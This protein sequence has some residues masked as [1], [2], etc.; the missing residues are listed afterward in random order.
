MPADGARLASGCPGGHVFTTRRTW[1]QIA[2]I[3]EL[4]QD[5]ASPGSA[6]EYAD[7]D[8][9]GL[10][11]GAQAFRGVRGKGEVVQLFNALLAL[12]PFAA[13]ALTRQNS[14]ASL[15]SAGSS[16]GGSP[17]AFDEILDMRTSARTSLDGGKGKRARPSL[18]LYNLESPH[19]E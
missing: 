14:A 8:L 5:P 16:A 2:E 6:S 3:F 4:D 11:Q 13:R 12:R 15:R 9:Y 1:E 19:G 7:L 18:D 10:S 17:A